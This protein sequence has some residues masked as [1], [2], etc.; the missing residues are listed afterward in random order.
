MIL[1]ALNDKV[2]VDLLSLLLSE[3]GQTLC[4]S[5]LFKFFWLES[6]I[7]HSDFNNYTEIF[8]RLIL[9]SKNPDAFI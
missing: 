1:F 4:S 3:T 2:V 8:C 6:L 9:P 5:K 7:I